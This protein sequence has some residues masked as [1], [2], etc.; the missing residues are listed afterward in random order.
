MPFWIDFIIYLC[1][2]S[3]EIGFVLRQVLVATDVAARGLDIKGVSAP[4]QSSRGCG[5][6]VSKSMRTR[7]EV[8]LVVNYDAANNTEVDI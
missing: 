3:T 2:L 6:C 7:T 8:G 5:I 1:F 4:M